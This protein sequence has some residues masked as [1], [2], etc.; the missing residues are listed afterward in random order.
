MARR[1]SYIP[2][3]VKL[4]ATLACLLPQ[5]QRDD[6]RSRKVSHKEVL[7]LFHFDHIVLHAID[8]ADDWWNLDPKQAETHKVKSRDDTKIVAKIKRIAK[9]QEELRRKLLKPKNRRAKPWGLR[10]RGF[11]PTKRRIQSRNNLRRN[12]DNKKP[13]GQ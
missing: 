10:S 2:F 8:G 4:A 3:P 1:R 6:L 7:R 5:D 12:P 13:A 11:G 9:K